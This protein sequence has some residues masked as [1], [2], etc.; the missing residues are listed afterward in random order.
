MKTKVCK[1]CCDKKYNNGIVLCEQVD[2][3]SDKDYVII[4]NEISEQI[5]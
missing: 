4:T 5:K 3:D 2:F 1:I